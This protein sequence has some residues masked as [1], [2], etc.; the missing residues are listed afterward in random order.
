MLQ[1]N[2]VS[3]RFGGLRVLEDLNLST[4]G[5]LVHGL[6][7]PN[8]AGKT[9][10][11]NLI[12]GLLQPTSGSITLDGRSLAGMMPYEIC[13][14][15]VARTFQNI[16]IFGQLSLEQNVIVGMHRHMQYGAADLLFRTKKYVVFEEAALERASELLT[17]VGLDQKADQLASTLSYGEQRRLE[18]ARALATDPALLLLDEPA[19]G[20]NS[21]EK[22]DLMRTV[23]GIRDKGL[24]VI[25][26]EHDMKFVMGLCDCVAVLNFGRIIAQGT[27]SEVTTDP[28]VISAY[29]G[30]EDAVE[31][32]PLA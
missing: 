21:S 1:L 30:T 29:L 15:G 31:A 4:E 16:R 3:K 5:G 22:A 6:I 28:E 9:T 20:M 17:Q 13:R 7:G 11:L 18:I 24:S 26:I 25:L 10:V 8:G 27:P 23:M 14:L 32:A 12:T 19:A 2:S